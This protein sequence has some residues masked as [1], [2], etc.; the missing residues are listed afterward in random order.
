MEEGGGKGGG[1]FVLLAFCTCEEGG[2]VLCNE[3]NDRMEFFLFWTVLV[4]FSFR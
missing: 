2:C 4:V 1:K 3:W